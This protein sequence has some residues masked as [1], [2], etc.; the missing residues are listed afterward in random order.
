[1]KYKIKHY[2]CFLKTT[3]SLKEYVGDTRGHTEVESSQIESR[4]IAQEFAEIA[5]AL[6]PEI[7]MLEKDGK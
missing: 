4:L 5:T 2:H 7:I 3:K 1:M 6:E